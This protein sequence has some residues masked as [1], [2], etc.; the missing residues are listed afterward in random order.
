MQT[1]SGGGRPISSSC[2]IMLQDEEGGIVN[3]KVI[4][5]MLSLD[6]SQTDGALRRPPPIIYLFCFFML[7]CRL[8]S[9]LSF[10]WVIKKTNYGDFNAKCH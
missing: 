9:F 8:L 5:S 4:K 6:F 3:K 2:S 7:Y 10:E 1:D